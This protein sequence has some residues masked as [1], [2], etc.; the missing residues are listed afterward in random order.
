MALIAI[1][2]PKMQTSTQGTQ[3]AALAIVGI[4]TK[5]LH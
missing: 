5:L 2:G 1:F 3:I 4:L